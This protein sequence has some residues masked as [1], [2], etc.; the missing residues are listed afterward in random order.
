MHMSGLAR[1]LLVSTP[2]WV[3]SANTPWYQAEGDASMPALVLFPGGGG[4]PFRDKTVMA[5]SRYF[6]TIQFDH[7]GIRHSSE[8]P[9]R[10]TLQEMQADARH[11]V[12]DAAARY[13][14]SSVAFLGYSSGTFTSIAVAEALSGT[15]VHV[16]AMVFVNPVWDFKL[17]RTKSNR[18]VTQA[19]G[20]PYVESFDE[21]FYTLGH[22]LCSLTCARERPLILLPTCWTVFEFGQE[23][24][25]D[26]YQQRLALG[27]S[28][29]A[30]TVQ[31]SLH[32]PVWVLAGIN[33]RIAPFEDIDAS[34][35][36]AT[37]F[38]LIAFNSGHHIFLE[39]DARFELEMAK[40][41]RTLHDV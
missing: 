10:D 28:Y 32:L 29:F 26:A 11:V 31:T 20:L 9:V 5:L 39:E 12:L 8:C 37:V 34:T 17:A 23:G 27:Q 2:M 40:I 33:D 3:A 21:L 16:S 13:N 41:S 4:A 18:C 22:S 7:C 38:E 14:L 1:L 36:N 24:V 30:Q 15:G 25:D 6:F 19:I 35:M